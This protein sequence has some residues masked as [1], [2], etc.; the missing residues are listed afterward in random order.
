M[1][2]FNFNPESHQYTLDGKPLPSVTGIVASTGVYD[3]NY[4]QHRKEIAMA[5]GSAVHKACYLSDENRL[6][7][8]TLSEIISPYLE[9]WQKFRMMNPF[10]VISSEVPMYHRDLMYAGII[11]RVVNLKDT[12]ILIDIKT[13]A[14]HE[15]AERLQT[16]G[17]RQL[18]DVN[19]PDMKIQKTWIVRLFSNSNFEIDPIVEPKVDERAFLSAF[20][21]YRFLRS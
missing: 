15:K 1:T 12:I 5:K 9:A 4:N 21:I 11:D 6:N 17:Y 8:K 13:G 3:N 19:C 20:N 2:D 16:G 18:W 14:K 7:F 10:R